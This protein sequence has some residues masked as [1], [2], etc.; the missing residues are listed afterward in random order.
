MEKLGSNSVFFGG[1]NGGLGIADLKGEIYGRARILDTET[2]SLQ[3]SLVDMRMKVGEPLRKLDFRPVHRDRTIRRLSV[4]VAASGRSFLSI[5]RN[6]FT[7]AFSNSM[8]PA[9]F[10]SVVRLSSPKRKTGDSQGQFS[11]DLRQL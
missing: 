1:G 11:N 3:D 2:I 4:R 6:H 7:W 8:Y 10:D 5:D 9:P